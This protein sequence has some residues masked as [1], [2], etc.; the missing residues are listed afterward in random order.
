[1][2]HQKSHCRDIIYLLDLMPEI[3]QAI[4]FDELPH[5]TTIQK[6]AK[7]FGCVKINRLLKA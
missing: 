1:M 2:K 5:Y 7:R 4:G 3:R 6:F